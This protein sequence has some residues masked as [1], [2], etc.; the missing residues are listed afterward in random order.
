MLFRD[1]SG[2]LVIINRSDYKNDSIYYRKIASIKGGSQNHNSTPG[3]GSIDRI[4]YL[5]EKSVR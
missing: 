2:N 5:V 3:S 1:E 4:M